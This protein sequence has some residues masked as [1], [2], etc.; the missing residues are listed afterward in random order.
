MEPPANTNITN[1]DPDTSIAAF[2]LIGIQLDEVRS[3]INEQLTASAIDRELNQ[4]LQYINNQSGKMLRPGLVLLSYRVVRD[5]S[6][7]KNTQYAICNTQDEVIRVAA[8]M[9]MIHN[10][11]L[12]HDDVIDDG[13]SRRGLP[14]VNKLWGNEAAVLLGDFMLSRVLKKCSG[15]EPRIAGMIAA[16]AA[17]TCEGELRQV[18]QRRNWRLSE[19]EYIDIITEKSAAFFSS[20]CGLGALLARG[21]KA[22]IRMLENFG[23][24]AGIAFQIADD[25]LDMIGDEGRT[26]KTGGSD[27]DKNK[28]T[29]TVIHLLKAIDDEERKRVYKMLNHTVTEGKAE[30]LEMLRSYG[31]LEFAHNVAHKF[32]DKA[33]HALAEFKKSDAKKS[34][35]ETAR[36]IAARARV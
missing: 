23:L 33:I 12:L 21:S 11:T 20:C 14:T 16:A 30:L 25:L 1:K 6:C 8:I 35:I 18:V 36:F 2:R 5:A 32:V 9:E 29:L 4:L 28:L 7:E 10:A 13:Q 27:V 19:S 22:Q 15:L 31:S 26:G 17:R 3:L 24:N 34:L